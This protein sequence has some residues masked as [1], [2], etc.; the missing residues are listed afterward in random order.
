MH[1]QTAVI[2]VG[3]GKFSAKG[4]KLGFWPAENITF[5]RAVRMAQRKVSFRSASDSSPFRGTCSCVYLLGSIKRLTATTH[6]RGEA[7][8]RLSGRERATGDFHLRGDANTT[9]T[10]WGATIFYER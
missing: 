6:S 4:E 5:P 8:A 2:S 10:P 9:S 3:K 7:P 1:E